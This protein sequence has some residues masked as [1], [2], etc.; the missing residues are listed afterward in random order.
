MLEEKYTFRIIGDDDYN[1]KLLNESLW[2]IRENTFENLYD[3]QKSLTNIHRF[4]FKLS[5]FSNNTRT[6]V[7]YNIPIQFIHNK[8]RIAYRHSKFY[9]KLLT[10]DD[11][12]NHPDLFV[13]TIM[14]FIDGNLYTNYSILPMEDITSIVFN[15]YMYYPDD[16]DYVCDGFLRKDFNELLESDPNVSIIM[17]STH[18][19]EDIKLNRYTLMNYTNVPEY[20]GVPMVDFIKSN[21]FSTNNPHISLITTNDNQLYKY[22]IVDTTIRNNKLYPDSGKVN[23]LTNTFT[24]IKNIYPS[25]YL[26][27]IHVKP[28]EKFFEVE[29]QDMPVPIENIMVYKKSGSNIYFDHT[30]K[31]TMYYPN[32]YK[33]DRDHND[34]LIIHVYYADDTTSLGNHYYNELQLYYRFVK[35]VKSRYENNTIP[36]FIKNYKSVTVNY[37]IKD[38]LSQSADHLRYKFN[39]LQEIITNEGAYYYIY[40]DKLVGYVPRYYVDV[41]EIKNLAARYRTNNF[42]EIKDPA[43]QEYFDEPCYLFI[44]RHDSNNDQIIM[45]IDNLHHN[46]K[47]DYSDPK[48]RYIYIPT[49]LINPNSIIDVEKYTD[50]VLFMKFT[51]NNTGSYIKID[52]TTDRRIRADEIFITYNDNE[53]G[54]AKYLDRDFYELYHVQNGQFDKI[55]SDRFYKYYDSIYFKLTNEEFIGVNLIANTTNSTFVMESV[56][57]NSFEFEKFV[58]NNR[59]N[60]MLFKNGKLVPKDATK[61]IFSEYANGPHLL[62]SLLT[63]SDEDIFTFVYNPNKYNRVYYQSRIPENGVINVSSDIE[64][65]LS[66]KWHDFYLNGNKLTKNNIT[67]IAPYIMIISNVNTRYNLEIYEKNF[68]SPNPIYKEDNVDDEIIGEIIIPG[69]IPDDEPDIIED[70]II[71]IIGLLEEILIGLIN[72][73]WQQIT[74]VI[75]LKYP[76]AF[77]ENNNLYVNPDKRIKMERDVMLNPDTQTY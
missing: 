37:D 12:F 34:E 33:I 44:F 13:N 5:E 19:E 10:Y 65:P 76:R 7:S 62:K 59:G 77:D 38:Y 71:D 56:G 14:V 25:E 43:L 17:M 63:V 4:D 48:Y 39:K 47:Y 30:A 50:E 9:K 70:V 69:N 2:T 11:V 49:R 68:G 52:Y 55:Q 53:T 61:V 18:K 51:P 31:I 24:Y 41:S 15:I 26:T 29:L 36:E 58:N 66:F 21:N 74:D 20:L 42:G 72:P 32:I 54:K 60:L 75:I 23:V 28:G 3:V 67:I 35:D 1:I 8:N 22:E 57:K 73:D 27:T 45:F 6:Q 64:K 46:S 16:P 40:L